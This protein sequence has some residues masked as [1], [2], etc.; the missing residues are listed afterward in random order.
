M[1]SGR[2]LSDSVVGRAGKPAGREAGTGV[3]PP[4]GAGAGDAVGDGGR[5]VRAFTA[6]GPV[7]KD[8]EDAEAE[9]A[10]EAAAGGAGE[11]AAAAAES[12]DC[13]VAPLTGA[14]TLAELVVGTAGEATREAADGC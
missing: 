3:E 5:T 11:T 1:T 2:F 10:G 9:G 4:E 14:A 12:V 6:L 8:D 7:G 13:P